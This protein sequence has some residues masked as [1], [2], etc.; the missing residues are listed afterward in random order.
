MNQQNK[1]MNPWATVWYN[2]RG[3]IR[4]LVETNQ[5]HSFMLLI[6]LGGWGN[7]L[8]YSASYGVVDFMPLGQMLLFCVVA[9]PVAALIGVYLWSWLL[10]WSS[11]MMGG[12]ANRTELRTGIAWSLAPVVYMLPLWGIKYILFRQELFQSDKP[13][14]ESH[15]FLS[16]LYGFFQVIDIFISV[17]SFFILLSALMELNKFSV[18]RSIGALG[19][20]FLI[21]AIP[22]LL[23]LPFI[24]SA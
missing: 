15:Q 22:L 8:S 16:A 20:A 24:G 11:R 4:H 12:T 9:G 13:F 5:M 6:T 23:L 21:M 17:Y 19:I 1:K 2:P 14:I 18:W 7:A 10:G 3:T